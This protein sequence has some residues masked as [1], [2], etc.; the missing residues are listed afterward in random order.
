MKYHTGTSQS[1]RTTY[2]CACQYRYI[3]GLWDNCYDWCDGIYFSGSNIYAILNPANF[4]DNSNGTL[5][6][7]DGT[8]LARATSSNYI[9]AWT[10]NPTNS[11]YEYAIYPSA[12]SGS[13]STY[14]TDRCGYNSSG[15][16]LFVGGNYAQDQYHGLFHLSGYNAASRSGASVGC[17]IMKLP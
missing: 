16:V 3:E 10:S 2:G 15:V 9:S 12:V 5:L 17:R 8:N 13:E 11:G 1:S 6:K 4:S 14:V 7:A